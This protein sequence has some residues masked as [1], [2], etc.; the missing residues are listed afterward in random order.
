[1]YYFEGQIPEDRMDKLLRELQI[2]APEE[3]YAQGCLARQNGEQLYDDTVRIVSAFFPPP[4]TIPFTVRLCNEILINHLPGNVAR[5]LELSN[6]PEIQLLR[7]EPGYF[8]AKHRDV[9]RTSNG[10][11][12]KDNLLGSYRSFTLSIQLTDPSEYEGGE[13]VVYKDNELTLKKNKG[14]YM[15]FPSMTLHEAKEVTK[16]VREALTCWFYSK[17]SDS[18]WLENKLNAWLRSTKEIQPT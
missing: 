6:V 12:Y 4:P 5:G 2:R 13:M 18:V 9:L 11:H 15:L 8:F 14:S 10:L 3:A 16:G 1:M 7:Y 17:G